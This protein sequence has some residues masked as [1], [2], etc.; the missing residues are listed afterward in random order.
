[1]IEYLKLYDISNLYQPRLSQEVE[2]VVRSGIYLYGNETQAF[3]KEFAGYCGAEHCYATANGLDALTVILMAYKHMCGWRS[4]DEVIVSAH[5]FV[6]T[7]FAIIRAGMRPVVCDAA[8]DNY[9]MDTAALESLITSRTRAI[10]PV[11]LYG[12]LC[13]MEK[14][15]AVASA[16]NLKVIED[17]AQ[18][19]GAETAEGRKAGV[20]GHAAAFSFYPGKNLGALSDA[21]AVVTNDSELAE[22]VRIIANYG[23]HEKY[24]HVL[25]G[26]NSR[27][28]EIQAAVLRVKLPYLDKVTA[29]RR[30]IARMYGK[31]ISND[32]VVIPYGGNTACS[33]FHVYPVFCDR[34]D[35]LKQY[36]LQNG[37]KTLIHYPQAP[38]RQPALSEFLGGQMSPVAERICG[39]E[40]SLPINSALTDEEIMT[41]IELINLYR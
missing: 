23:A 32:R 31:G 37:V 22:T 25:E 24:H 10:M 5:T 30:E 11:H 36:L 15:N 16:Y 8:P 13:D 26:I 40:L 35:E 3:E 17:A 27:I 9:L 14:I 18:A 39:T 7:I 28:D 38:C 29:R 19:H 34:R 33:V 12:A 41:I 6:A 21:G 2:R 4:D 20:L 1:M